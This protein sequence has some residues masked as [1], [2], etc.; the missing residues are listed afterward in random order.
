MIG[1]ADARNLISGWLADASA[2][3]Q[4]ELALL[5]AQTLET[6][7]GWVFFYTSKRFLES[8]APADALAGNAPM[9]VDRTLGSLHFTGTARPI[10][11]YMEEFRRNRSMVGL[12]TA[13]FI[14]SPAEN[15]ALLAKAPPE[16]MS[17]LRSVNGCI[18]HGGSLHIRGSCLQPDWHSLHHVWMGDNRLSAYYANVRHDDV[19]FAQDILGNQFLIR[20]NSVWRL[21]GE[22]GEIADL[23]MSWREFLKAATNNPIEFLS[24]QLFEDFKSGG[25]SVEPGQL[26]NV[27]PPLCT[28]EASNGVSVRAIPAL[29]QIRFLADFASQVA[30]VDNGAKIRIRVTNRT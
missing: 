26:L 14:G 23:R 6:E 9:I 20:S 22:T 17:F 21:E 12:T 15:L 10:A 16:Y 27:Y 25:G 30:G 28:N 24:L 13:S 5:E 19:P 4:I 7:F 18:V 3:C 1:S 2:S 29:E 11:E 8:G